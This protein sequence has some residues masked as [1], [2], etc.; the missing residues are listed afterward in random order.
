MHLTMQVA[1]SQGPGGTLQ[2]PP[3]DAEVDELLAVVVLELLAEVLELLAEVLELLAEVLELLAEVL[4]LL[5]DVLVLD[6]ELGSIVVVPEA[7]EVS[8]DV[9]SVCVEVSVDLPVEGAPPNPAPPRP[10]SELPCAQLAAATT[11][12]N[13]RNIRGRI[14]G[15]SQGPGTRE[16]RW[17][18]M[19]ITSP[20]WCARRGRGR[21]GQVVGA[22]ATRSA[23]IKQ[24][25]FPI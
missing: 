3:D 21:S 16:R 19:A 9:G 17:M 12:R 20:S 23:S 15:L 14:V 24:G 7:V 22:D 2:P 8:V 25:V 10:S 11:P 1:M 6:E 18:R 5:L 4:E 13:T